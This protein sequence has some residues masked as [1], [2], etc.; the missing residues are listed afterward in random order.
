MFTQ[1]YRSGYEQ[2]RKQRE[3]WGHDAFSNVWKMQ[4][5]SENHSLH[6]EFVE[7]MSVLF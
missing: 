2:A 7:L 4:L 1:N 5:Q 3:M 6:L